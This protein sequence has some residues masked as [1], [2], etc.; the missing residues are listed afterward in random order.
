MMDGQ[1]GRAKLM[2]RLF[3]VSSSVLS[4]DRR[5]NASSNFG[6]GESG[7]TTPTPSLLQYSPYLPA[8]T[9][10]SHLPKA[11]NPTVTLLQK[12]RGM[13]TSKLSQQFHPN[14]DPIFGRTQKDSCPKERLTSTVVAPS[15][16][17]P[18]ITN[19]PSL[20]RLPNINKI[21]TGRVPTIKV[22]S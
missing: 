4:W 19:P 16:P 2:I 20:H 21:P 3:S 17:P 6:G 9:P 7:S 12:A 5:T 13:S 15:S 22:R 8:S 10:T 14:D 1:V 18:P 11:P